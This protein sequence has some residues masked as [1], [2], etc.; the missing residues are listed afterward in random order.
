MKY[1]I[2]KL[3]TSRERFVNQ[4]KTGHNGRS[5]PEEYTALLDQY[6]EDSLHE[7]QL[8]VNLDHHNISCALV[9]IGGYG[10]RELCLHSDI[11][12]FLL[13]K[14]NVPAHA[15]GFVQEILFPLWDLSLELGYG[16]RSFKECLSLAR[17]DFE[18]FTAIIDARFIWGDY[19]LYLDLMER[20]HKK[21]LSKNNRAFKQWLDEHE[22]IRLEK[23]GDSR[24]LLEPNIKEGIGGLRDY[25]HMLWLA[26]AFAG[27]LEPPHLAFLAKLSY[28]EYQNLKQQVSFLLLVRNHLHDLSGRKNDHVRFQQQQEIASRLALREQEPSLA[29]EQFMGQL[30]AT[31]TSIKSLSRSFIAS[32]QPRN[33]VR[34]KGN[35][36]VSINHGLI[37]DRGEIGFSSASYVLSHPFS[38]ISIFEHSAQLGYP[39]CLKAQRLIRDCLHMVDDEFRKSNAAVSSFLKILN[40]PNHTFETLDQMLEVGLL[41]VFIPE[42]DGIKDRILFDAYHIYPVGIHSLQTVRYLKGLTHEK[43]ILLRDLF[44]E[45]QHPEHLFLAGLF[46]DIGKTA[47]NHTRKGAEITRNILTRFA[48]TD[49]AIADICFLVQHHL[50]LV[51]TAMRRDLNDEKVIVQCARL[52]GNKERLKML[53]LLTWADSKA[54]GPKAWNEWIASL[55]QELFFKVLHILERGELAT[56]DALRRVEHVKSEVRQYI[57]SLV[58]ANDLEA[59]FEMMSPRYV[60]TTSS[61]AIV[62]HLG[63]ADR[64]KAALRAE[65]TGHKGKSGEV[66]FIFEARKDDVAD[67]WQITFLAVDKPGLFS[68]IAGVLALNNIN[69]L[70]ADIYTWRDRTAVDVLRVTNPLDELFVQE[71]WTKVKEDLKDALTGR[72]SLD[73]RLGQQAADSILSGP[74]QPS[75]PP[76]VIVDNEASDF[77]TVIEV[78]AD[79]QLG[80]LYRITHTLFNLHLDIHIAKISTTVDQVA[81]VFYVRDLDGQKVENAKKVKEIKRALLHNLRHI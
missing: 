68:N 17:E 33:T 2:E 5:L 63:M 25:H 46:H 79:D 16:I 26:R 3:K 81:D 72:L 4:L 42:F 78:Y 13:F 51:E 18:M 31:M 36:S 54:T 70:S 28:Q 34:A 1:P 59:Y 80:L 64:L 66:I 62:Q 43:D 56:Q 45:L 50:L 58:N 47:S 38:L 60:L 76:Q 23:F 74:K 20:F 19:H 24:Y 22:E 77:Y 61:R 41:N 49:D 35:Q 53:Y 57:G 65:E 75:R 11:D 9:A 10:R 15:R 29:V 71:K 40:A 8:R 52:I 30:H 69:I 44:E 27:L 12:I 37:M 14:K 55:V 48:F 67:C 21:I 39:L 7:S 32:L 6:F 73:S